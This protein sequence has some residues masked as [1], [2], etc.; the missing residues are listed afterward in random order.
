MK[1]L[2]RLWRDVR[3]RADS[4]AAAEDDRND[5]TKKGKKNTRRPFEIVWIR[6]CWVTTKRSCKKN[7]EENSEGVYPFHKQQPECVLWSHTLQL[8]PTPDAVGVGGGTRIE[9]SRRSLESDTRPWRWNTSRRQ[10]SHRAHRALTKRSRSGG[11]GGDA[12]TSTCLS[13][14]E[15]QSRTSCKNIN[16]SHTLERVNFRSEGLADS[17]DSF[18]LQKRLH[19][20]RT[21]CVRFVGRQLA[22]RRIAV[23]RNWLH[24]RGRSHPF[25]FTK[26]HMMW[27]RD[28]Y[29]PVLIQI[30]QIKWRSLNIST[31]MS[32][33]G[34]NLD[35]YVEK[36]IHDSIYVL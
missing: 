27:P 15:T 34:T 26:Y 19:E 21:P 5:N 7:G 6:H 9:R 16:T 24:V 22:A 17:F 1:R 31:F 30:I 3:V 4:R 35:I 25:I 12:G 11:Q 14:H 2:V 33:G 20:A 36:I 32:W 23:R 8:R 13:Q 10:T 28:L 18:N 29:I